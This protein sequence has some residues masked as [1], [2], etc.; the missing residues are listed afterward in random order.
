MGRSRALALLSASL[1]I[2]LSSCQSPGASQPSPTL[3]ASA[4]LAASPGLASVGPMAVARAVQTETTLQ[5]GRVL[6]AGGCTTDGCD[7]GSAG[8]ATAELFDPRSRRFVPTGSMRVSRDDHRAVLLNDGRVFLAGG[9]T[10]AGVTAGTELYDPATGRFAT[11]ATM[12]SPRAAAAA[13]KLAGGRVLLIG[14]F[15]DER[16]TLASTEIFDPSA[17]TFVPTGSMGIPRGVPAAALLPDGRVLVA[18]GINEGKV[19]ATAEIYDPATGHFSP[20]GPMATARYKAAAVTLRDG[21]ALVLGGSG[22]IDGQQVY[23]STE[24][25]DAATGT[26]APGPAMQSA[27]YKLID[28]V[29]SLANGDLLVAGG[30]PR[31]E[32]YEQATGRFRTVAGDLGGTRLFLTAAALD[33]NRALLVGGYDQRIRPTAQAWLFTGP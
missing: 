29:V 23:A 19:V 17:N 25:F 2:L 20:V 4:S 30:G 7:L 10:A 26:F 8:G 1:A 6:V 31:V 11:G 21:S 12:T 14:G 18:G 33:G 27:R 5:D 9:W 24:R 3:A 13:V 28:S 15:M 16:R 32:L 22:D